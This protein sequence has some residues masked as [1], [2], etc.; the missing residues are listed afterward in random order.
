MQ[1]IARNY[2]LKFEKIPVA[3]VWLF[4]SKNRTL[5]KSYKKRVPTY[6]SYRARL[7]LFEAG[8]FKLEPSAFAVNSLSTQTVIQLNSECIKPKLDLRCLAMV[9]AH[10]IIQNS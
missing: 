4:P 1:K 9:M 10:V 8:H 3:R 6:T 5:T 2:R 7:R